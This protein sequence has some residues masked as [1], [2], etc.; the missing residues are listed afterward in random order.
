[1]TERAPRHIVDDL[2][3]KLLADVT[4]AAERT[5]SLVVHP[6]DRALVCFLAFGGVLG[7]CLRYS[8]HGWGQGLAPEALTDLLWQE[9]IRPIVLGV[10]DGADLDA[11]V[12]GMRGVA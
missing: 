11:I 5:A 7:M 10:I 1:M 4:D 2:G 6:S 8:E 9:R 3:R 12:G